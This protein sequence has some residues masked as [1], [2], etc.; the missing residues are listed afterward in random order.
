MWIVPGNFS[1]LQISYESITVVNQYGAVAGLPIESDVLR[2]ASGSKALLWID[3]AD[4]HRLEIVVIFA[5]PVGELGGDG[6]ERTGCAA[7]VDNRVEHGA[8]S[9][10]VDEHRLAR[11][12]GS[13]QKDVEALPQLFG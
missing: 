3:G 8:V 6:V 10:H 5:V 4:A 1:R 2:V 12:D 13:K 11:A 9:D 7:R